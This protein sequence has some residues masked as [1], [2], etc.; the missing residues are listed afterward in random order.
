[1]GAMEIPVIGIGAGASTDGQ[2]LVLHDLLGI[3]DGYQPKFVKRYADVRGEMLRG[4]QAYAED[5][6]TRAFP[7]PEHTY[8]I[9]P[10]ELHRLQ[11]GLAQQH[12]STRKQLVHKF[13]G[14]SQLQW[15]PHGRT[16]QAV[17]SEGARVLRPVR[18]GRRQHRAG[19][20]PARADA[21]RVARPRRAGPRGRD[22]R[23]GG[24]PDHARH[25][26]AAEPDVRHADRPRGHLRARVRARRHRRLDRGGRRLLRAVPDRGADVAGAAAGADPQPRL[27]G[28]RRTRSRGCG[29]SATSTTSRSR[30]TAT[31]TRAT[32]SSARRWPRCS[33]RGST[34][35]W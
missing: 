33:R 12:R 11:D 19:G 18:G 23:A 3:N 30:S 15:P 5:V 29:T 28:G 2:V 24:R 13:T 21:R 34:R 14:R 31:R 26:P 20:R 35:C 7:G 27:P 17:R 16:V 10:E 9:A 6:R 22:L 8:G 25:H 32:A 1:M 4:L